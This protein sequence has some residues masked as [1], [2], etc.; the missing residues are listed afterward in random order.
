M[1]VH[2]GRF[3]TMLAQAEAENGN[4]LPDLLDRLFKQERELALLKEKQRQTTN[5]LASFEPKAPP[6]KQS[7]KDQGGH[8]IAL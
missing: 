5:Y 3:Q 1:P 6:K 7:G 4:I 2:V 8:G